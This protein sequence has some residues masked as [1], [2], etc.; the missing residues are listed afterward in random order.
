VFKIKKQTP[1]RKLIEA[2]CQRQ[3]V[4]Q[5]SIRFLYDGNRIQPEQMPKDVIAHFNFQVLIFLQLDMED[6]D[7]IDAVLS[8]VP[9]Y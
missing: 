2:Y 1:L 6:N 4:D 9:F 3:G 7:I 8:Q 5:N